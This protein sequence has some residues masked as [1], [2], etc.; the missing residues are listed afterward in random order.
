[1]SQKRQQFSSGY[2]YEAVAKYSRAVRVGNLVFVAGTTATDTDGNIVGVGDAGAQ[3]RQ[4][5]ANLT[6]GLAMASAT[7]AD[8][9]RSRIYIT[10]AADADAVIA[11]HAEVFADIRPVATLV[12]VAGLVNPD[13][14]VEIELDAVIIDTA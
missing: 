10:N 2:H 5:F 3:A 7:M 12:V 13:M 4:V 8:V 1:M 6:R 14:L 11:V 9:V